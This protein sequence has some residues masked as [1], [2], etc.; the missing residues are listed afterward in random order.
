LA[1]E[2]KS[3]FRPGNVSNAKAT[4]KEEMHIVISNALPPMSWLPFKLLHGHFMNSGAVWM[5][6]A[7]SLA[8]V[9]ISA[10]AA[11]A[12]LVLHAPDRLQSRARWPIDVSEST[13]T[14]SPIP[15]ALDGSG[16]PA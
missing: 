9:A 7:L 3:P 16:T 15:A 5:L 11:E 1:A 14:V 10:L 4:R 2:L 12:A 8:I 13:V 6:I